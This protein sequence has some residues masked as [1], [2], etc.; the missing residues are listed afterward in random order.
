MIMISFLKFRA[1]FASWLLMNIL[2]V[3]VPRYGAY[4]MLLTGG[5]MLLTNILYHVHT[6]TRPLIIRFEDTILSFHYGWCFWLVLGTGR[7]TD[8]FILLLPFSICIPSTNVCVLR[9][10]LLLF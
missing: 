3:T 5:L 6:P 4:T 10:G 7:A 8:F 1:A 9:T 2:L